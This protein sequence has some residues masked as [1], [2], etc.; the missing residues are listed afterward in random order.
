MASQSL[1]IFDIIVLR[2]GIVTFRAENGNNHRTQDI[3]VLGY[4]AIY[5]PHFKTFRHQTL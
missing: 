5:C 2:A 4:L 1:Q 3:Y